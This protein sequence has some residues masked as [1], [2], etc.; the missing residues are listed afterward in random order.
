M[1]NHASELPI[2]LRND[3]VYSLGGARRSRDDVPGSPLAT[4]SKPAL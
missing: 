1:E 4:M 2:W 3:L